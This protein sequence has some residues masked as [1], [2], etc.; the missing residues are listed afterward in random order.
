MS[1]AR[2]DNFK[3]SLEQIQKEHIKGP[4]SGKMRPLMNDRKAA[5]DQRFNDRQAAFK[6]ISDKEMADPNS[7]HYSK[8]RPYTPPVKKESRNWVFMFPTWQEWI[9]VKEE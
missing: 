3:K 7:S 9:E 2:K 5:A 1:D 4:L 8:Y 6:A